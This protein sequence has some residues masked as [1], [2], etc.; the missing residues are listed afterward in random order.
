MYYVD[1]YHGG[2]KGHMPEGAWRDV[3]T[4]LKNN[5]DWKIC[6]ELEP[7]SWD[8]VKM[9]DPDSY[10]EL[11]EYLNSS[12][13]NTRTEIVS[14]S[15][16]Q[17]YCW[18]IG[19]ESNI[20]HLLRG[21]EIVKKHFPNHV[22]D[23]Y[24]VQE[25]CWTS[26]LPQIL[27]S[28]GF[29][30]AVLKNPGT[31]WGGY[32]RGVNAETINWV[33]PD[34]TSIQCVPRY[35]CEELV[36]C[37]E[38]E[39]ADCKRKFSEKCIENGIEHPVGM[40]FQDLG[41]AAEPRIS[42]QKLEFVTWREYFEKIA[43]KTIMDW[44]FSQEDILCTLPWGEKTLH[45]MAKQVRDAENKIVQA[46]KL[47]AM[48]NVFSGFKYP[49]KKLTEAWDQL[50]LSQHH[51][52]WICAKTREGRN[53]WAWQA[54]AE[55]WISEELCNRV[56]DEAIASMNK[57]G[58]SGT[59]ADKTSRSIKVFNTLGGRRKT[60]A[61]KHIALLPGTRSISVKNHLG[62]EVPFQIIPTR[63]YKKDGSINACKLVFEAETPSMGFSTYFIEESKELP[64]FKGLKEV[65]AEDLG[66][67]I[68]IHSDLYT[69]TIDLEKGGIIS[70]L[71]DKK[72]K[73]EFV[74][75]TNERSFNEYRGYFIE[76][77]N[78]FSS[79]D[80]FAKANILENGPYRVKVEILGRIE[81]NNFK[82]SVIVTKS[83]P[84]IDFNVKFYFEKETWVG[85]PWDIEPEKRHTERKK[86]NHDDS[87]KLQAVFPTAL[88]PGDLYKNAAF[89]VCKSKNENTFFSGWDNIKHNIILNWVDLYDKNENAGIAVFSDRTTS[90]L[91][92][93]DHPLGI[94]LG[95]GWEAGFWWG[96]SSL[97]GIQESSYS[98]L[99]HQGNW[100]EAGVSY[101]NINL[102]EPYQVG[103]TSGKFEASKKEYS[104]FDIEGKGFEVSAVIFHGEAMLIRIFNAKTFEDD[105]KVILG[106]KYETAEIV[107]LKGECIEKPAFIKEINSQNSINFRMAGFGISTIKLKLKGSM[108]ES[109]HASNAK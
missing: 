42:D 26:S 78:W 9:N 15:Y 89:D 91:H 49:V 63:E 1:G 5:P 82:S 98:I 68:V 27:I 102:C 40:F 56:M 10:D 36:N 39:A 3:L 81:D 73:R 41:W 107:D 87:W 50:L 100:E 47:S 2:I 32:T 90:Y 109:I 52:A 103:I 92:G 57:D 88:S 106:C 74:D 99:P 38:T 61:E 46:E 13:L 104:A 11:K 16:A 86:S 51:D 23:T 7:I 105:C 33:G 19:G 59:Q 101:E 83:Q 94:T 66:R 93:K 62:R 34:G 72:M 24:A 48:A 35:G 44:H 37:W 64:E 69:I 4:A 76:K 84:R 70:G 79:T 6:I 22:I 45:V 29:K 54:G 31:A 30:R 12:S 80:T 85:E 43:S 8:Y 21:L 18:V 97:N 14:G 75:L 17:P 65:Y 20:R 58:L 53:N 71:Y 25:P 67:Y 95:W 55:T 28:L 77:K 96:K 60:S 108:E